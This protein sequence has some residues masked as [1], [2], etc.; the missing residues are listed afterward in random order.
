MREN[1]YACDAV[2]GEP[3]EPASA[4]RS[5]VPSLGPSARG[6]PKDP[7]NPVPS[8]G[9][10]GP[11]ASPG[12]PIPLAAEE[13]PGTQPPLLPDS[14]GGVCGVPPP[15]GSQEDSGDG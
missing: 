9:S 14:G 10:P 1:A 4:A 15:N 13:G 2:S 8:A 7:A 6:G 11:V 3:R 12:S 5:A